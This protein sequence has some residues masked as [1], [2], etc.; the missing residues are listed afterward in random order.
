MVRANVTTVEREKMIQ[1]IAKPQ[2]AI[3]TE[4]KSWVNF[5]L[6]NFYSDSS[7]MIT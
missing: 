7:N 5:I 2:T 1:K 4:S 3:Q 6:A